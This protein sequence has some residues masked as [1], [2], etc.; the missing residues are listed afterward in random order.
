MGGLN[1]RYKCEDSK[2]GVFW[3]GINVE[4]YLKQTKYGE[5]TESK[6]SSSL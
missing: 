4:E 6:V 3:Y 1:T 5:K 2:K